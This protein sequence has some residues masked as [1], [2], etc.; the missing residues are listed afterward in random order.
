MHFLQSKLKVGQ[1]YLHGGM[2]LSMGVAQV[3]QE[4]SQAQQGGLAW[5]S[6]GKGQ[7]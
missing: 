7:M 6:S 4:P 5:P 3:R 1:D 2:F